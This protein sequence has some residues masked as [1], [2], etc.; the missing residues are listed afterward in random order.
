[1]LPQRLHIS[2]RQQPI[3]SLGI[4]LAAFLLVFEV[5]LVV[6]GVLRGHGWSA[7]APS[8]L[9]HPSKRPFSF[10]PAFDGPVGMHIDFTTH[11][12]FDTAE[13][14]AEFAALL[15]SSGHLV[16]LDEPTGSPTT[17]AGPKAYTVTLFHQMKCLDVVRAQ[18]ADPSDARL[19]LT[20]HCLNY[21]RQ[22]VLCRP[23]IKVEPAVNSEG[24]AVRGYDAVCRDWTRVYEE[25]ERN[26]GA[27]RAW[28]NA[29][30]TEV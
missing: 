9:S 15:P 13:G 3:P 14:A 24:T 27:Y 4:V 2:L 17:S 21:L 23:N 6:I 18:Y 11:Y 30:A 28:V 10:A 5:P 1:M 7:D 19:P 25:A 20:N 16:Y 26:V 8:A 29:T 22:T 12:R